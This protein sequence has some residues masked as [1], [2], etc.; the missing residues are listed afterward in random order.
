M[1]KSSF[2][3]INREGACHLYENTKQSH[4]NKNSGALVQKADE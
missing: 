1:A 3:S 4:S 2:K